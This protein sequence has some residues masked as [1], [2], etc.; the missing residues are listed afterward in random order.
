[1]PNNFKSISDIL[2]KDKAL[3]NFRKSV[4]EQN[5]I[6]EFG[7]IFPALNNNVTTV[8]VKDHVLYLYV[9]NSVLRNE[10][11]INKKKVIEKINNHFNNKLISDIK[12]TN[13]RN[14]HR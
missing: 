14:R 2:K 6:E 1:M 13:F 11:N 7:D 10:L 12:F 3:K 8:K 9:E 5:I 4:E